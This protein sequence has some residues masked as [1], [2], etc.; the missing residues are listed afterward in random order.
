M[1]ADKFANIEVEPVSTNGEQESCD[2]LPANHY[3]IRTLA[4]I[5][6]LP[7]AEMMER[8]LHELS[9]RLRVARATRELLGAKHKGVTLEWP[10]ETL[11]R[12]DGDEC[13]SILHIQRGGKPIF[14]ITHTRRAGSTTTGLSR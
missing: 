8:C 6:N 2:D 1:K 4:D 5:Y 9:A 7:T 10:E 12:D 13:T 3:H 11:W 14:D